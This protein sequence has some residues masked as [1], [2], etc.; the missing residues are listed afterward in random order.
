MLQVLSYLALVA[1][2]VM[3]LNAGGML[4]FSRMEAIGAVL[5]LVIVGI[6]LLVLKFRSGGGG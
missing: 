5:A 4:D 3:G 1:L 2:A 6:V